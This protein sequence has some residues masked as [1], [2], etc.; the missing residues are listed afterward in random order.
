MVPD[1]VVLSVGGGGLLCGIIEGL[2]RNDMAHVPILA[3]ETEGADS[4]GASLRAGQH[5]EIED[6]IEHRHLIRRKES[7]ERC[8]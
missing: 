8:V 5:V 1:V 6:I 7:G 2:R 4:L 3:V